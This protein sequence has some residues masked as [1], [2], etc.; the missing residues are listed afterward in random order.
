VRRNTSRRDGSID[1]AHRV[2]L[3]IEL[4]DGKRLAEMMLRHGVGVQPNTSATLYDLDEDFF[5]EK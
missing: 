4:I 1:E 3:R 2:S 5:E